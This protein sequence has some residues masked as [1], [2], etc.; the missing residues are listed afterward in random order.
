MLGNEAFTRLG[1][2]S[3]VRWLLRRLLVRPP[4]FSLELLGAN[5]GAFEPFHVMVAHHQFGE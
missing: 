2:L 4:S 1:W 5:Y 3:P